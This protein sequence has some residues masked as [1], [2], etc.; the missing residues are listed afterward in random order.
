MVIILLYVHNYVYV[1]NYLAD[2]QLHVRSICY[3]QLAITFTLNFW[4]TLA[5]AIATC[6][7]YAAMDL[8]HA[9]ITPTLASY[10]FNISNCNCSQSILLLNKVLH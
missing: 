4:S 8:S 2:P 7:S 6:C 9:F 3:I 10:N 1:L 5:I